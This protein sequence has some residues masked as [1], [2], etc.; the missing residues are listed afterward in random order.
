MPKANI[1]TLS[2]IKKWQKEN[3]DKRSITQKKY[4]QGHQVE[5]AIKRTGKSDQMKEYFRKYYLKHRDIL[6]ARAIAYGSTYKKH[7]KSIDPAYKLASLLRTRLYAILKRK[8]KNGSAVQLLGCTT[9]EASQYIEKQFLPGMTWD[10]WS[11]DGWHID[12]IKPLSAFDLTDVQQ[13]ANACHYTNLRPMWAT[14]NIKK[15]GIKNYVNK[16]QL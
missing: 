8:S 13:L 3:P 5:I 16:P 2:R 9:E 7:R 11:R 10:N 6:L 15:G 4:R 1:K 14:D 12:H